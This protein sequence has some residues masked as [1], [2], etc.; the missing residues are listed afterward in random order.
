MKME[1]CFI[2]L[3]VDITLSAPLGTPQVTQSLRFTKGEKPPTAFPRRHGY[4]NK[5]SEIKARHTRSILRALCSKIFPSLKNTSLP[6]CVCKVLMPAVLL[7][8]VNKAGKERAE[9]KVSDLPS[10]DAPCHLRGSDRDP[11]WEKK[12][13]KGQLLQILHPTQATRI[14]REVRGA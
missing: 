13:M 1:S 10:G 3:C 4:N 7:R 11:Q 14:T 6:S 2:N 12:G 8:T 9:A 5:A